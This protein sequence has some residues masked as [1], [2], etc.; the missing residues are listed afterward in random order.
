MTLEEDAYDHEYEYDEYEYD[1]YEYDDDE[2][3]YEGE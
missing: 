3:E 1:E 2:Y